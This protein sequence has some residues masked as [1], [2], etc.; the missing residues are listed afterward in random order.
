MD[1]APPIRQTDDQQLTC[2]AHF[3]SIHDQ[4]DLLPALGLTFQPLARNRFIPLPRYNRRVSQQAAQAPRNTHQFRLTRDLP[5]NSTQI[6]RPALVYPYNQPD[7]T[8]NLRDALVGTQFP[9]SLNPSMIQGVDRHETS[10]VRFF[11]GKNNL[12]RSFVADQLLFVKVSGD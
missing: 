6:D 7:E 5:H 10:P 12:Y 11:C 9:N 3:A 1:G 2:K 4:P 8:A